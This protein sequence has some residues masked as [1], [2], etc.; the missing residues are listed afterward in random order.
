[1]GT[2]NTQDGHISA[3]PCSNIF[4]EV[5]KKQNKNKEKHKK[6]L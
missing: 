1:M 5:E 6:L 3:Y 4:L 2:L